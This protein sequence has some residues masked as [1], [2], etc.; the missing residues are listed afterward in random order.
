[1]ILR[2]P[3]SGDIV[4]YLASASYDACSSASITTAEQQG[5]RQ[6]E[7][8]LRILRKL[9]GH[10]NMYLVST[11]PNFGTRESRHI[12]ARYQL[13]VDYALKGRHFQIRLP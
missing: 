10:E 3:L 4:T 9:P 8:Y 6:A 5:R 2:L 1:V 11:G 13:Q 12:D 7:E